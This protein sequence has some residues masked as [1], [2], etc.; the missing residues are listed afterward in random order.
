MPRKKQSTKESNDKLVAI[1]KEWQKVENTSIDSIRSGLKK[2]KNPL[3]AQVLKIIKYDSTMH[4][5]VQQFIIDSLEKKAVTL[6]PE[7]LAEVWDVIEAHIK[8]ERATIALGQRARDASNNFVHKYFIDYLQ[9]EEAKHDELL[10]KLED[11][12]KNMYPYA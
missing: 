12:K 1:M 9:K 6:T 5:H 4:H 11:V 3:V 2:V 8:M 7:E 10:E